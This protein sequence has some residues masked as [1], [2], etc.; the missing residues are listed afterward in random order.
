MQVDVEGNDNSEAGDEGDFSDRPNE[1][2]LENSNPM[3]LGMRTTLLTPTLCMTV[4]S[5]LYKKN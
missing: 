1:L 2:S 4:D 3:A 5:K